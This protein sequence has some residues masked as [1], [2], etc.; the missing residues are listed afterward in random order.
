MATNTESKL[1]THRDSIREHK[2]I[3]F[4]VKCGSTRI[5]Q[6]SINEL[7]CYDCENTMVWDA[8]K[9]SIR[10][11]LD[12]FGESDVRRAIQGP[13]TRRHT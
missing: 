5:D 8:S 11:Y 1:E 4:C 13:I 12:E 6:N 10:R 2:P 3:V 7:R 9:F